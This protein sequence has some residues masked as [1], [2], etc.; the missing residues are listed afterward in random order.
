LNAPRALAVAWEVARSRELAPAERRALLAGFDAVLGLDLAR[1][2]PRGE[3]RESDPRI[4]ALVAAREAARKR[5][6]FA[7]ADR[8]RE[9]L[10]A[11]GIALEDTPAGPRWRRVRA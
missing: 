11:E 5:R 1:A 7:E 2:L 6:D 10:A 8:L 9:A 3:R 4:D